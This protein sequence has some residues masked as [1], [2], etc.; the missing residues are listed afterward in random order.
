[1]AGQVRVAHFGIVH[2]VQFTNA[3]LWTY[4]SGWAQLITF[5]THILRFNNEENKRTRSTTEK[6]PKKQK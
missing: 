5:T 1:M 2:H 3:H 4:I 6:G